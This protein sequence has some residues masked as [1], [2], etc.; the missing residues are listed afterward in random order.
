MRKRILSSLKGTEKLTRTIYNEDGRVLLN[1]GVVLNPSYIKRMTEMGVRVVYIED[2][3][4]KGINFEDFLSD[5]VRQKC[6]KDIKEA[7]NAY[8]NTGKE[9]YDILIDC[10]QVIL[11]DILSNKGVIFNMDDS[12]LE[13]EGIVPH[14]INVTALIAIVGKKMGFNAMKLKDIVTGSILH[15][16]GK[17]IILR[18]KGVPLKKLHTIDPNT[19]MEHPKSGY[20]LLNKLW[21]FSSVSK[22]MIL[23][24]HENCDGTGYP[25]SIKRKDIHETA[26]L[27]RICDAFDNMMIGNTDSKKP[28]PFSQIIE[29]LKAMDS[30]FDNDIVK[31]L[32]KVVPA[33]PTGT[34]VEL[35]T[36]DKAIVSKQNL[37]NLSLPVVRLF[38]DRNGKRYSQPREIDLKLDKDVKVLDV[39]DNI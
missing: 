24:H 2:E 27:L 33:Y 17:V 11:D 14:L 30:Y 15:D 6:K 5:K 22:I 32:E 23:M 4:S 29:Y 25:L 18:E 3:I 10:G 19:I 21:S 35:S 12:R 9:N 13:N 7:L 38:E 37:A 28:I 36:K 1:P 20:E 34:I 39:L 8:L 26:K 31:I 16:Y